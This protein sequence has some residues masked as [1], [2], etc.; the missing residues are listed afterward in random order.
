[1]VSQKNSYTKEL[2]SQKFLILKNFYMSLT[3]KSYT[4]ELLY[5]LT[6]NNR[7]H[8]KKIKIVDNKNKKP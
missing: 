4:K 7:S 2:V 6:K 8:G 1:M 5:G 3:K